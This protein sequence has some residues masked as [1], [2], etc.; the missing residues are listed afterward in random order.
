MFFLSISWLPDL[1]HSNIIKSPFK[2]INLKE[3]NI[4]ATIK[5][6]DVYSYGLPANMAD[7]LLFDILIKAHEWETL[8]LFYKLLTLLIL[9]VN[10]NDY[11]KYRIS[12]CINVSDKHTV[13]NSYAEEY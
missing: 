9:L 7:L 5:F 12:L 3:A 10:L 11:I 8:H 1:F 4:K 2:I 13:L 6:R